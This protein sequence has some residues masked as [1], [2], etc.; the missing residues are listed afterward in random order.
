VRTLLLLLLACGPSEPGPTTRDTGPTDTGTIPTTTPLPAYDG[1]VD[2]IAT[3]ADGSPLTGVRVTLCGGI[4][5]VATVEPSGAFHFEG[6]WPVSNVLETVDYPGDDQVDAVLHWS[7]FFDLVPLTENEQVVLERPMRMH[8]VVPARGLTGPQDLQVAPD[9][10]VAFDAD[11][12]G[13]DHVLPSPAEEVALGAAVLPPEDW[14][15]AVGDWTPIAAWGFAI[16]D[17]EIDDGFAATATLTEALPDGHE[18]AF[19]VADYVVGF[20]DGVM[21][22]ETA[23]ISADRLTVSTP[24]DGGIDRTTLWVLAI[25]PR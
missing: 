17:L 2:G 9:L 13:V 25:R 22:V 7:R 19:L 23:E 16:W 6:V 11:R 8:P 20:R 3:Y 10:R 21:A 5:Q 15:R 18:A 24:A 14:P 4:C 12:I 1:T